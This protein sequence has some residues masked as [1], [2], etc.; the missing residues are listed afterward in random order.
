LQVLI[1]LCVPYSRIYLSFLAEELRVKVEE[2]VVL[3]ADLILDGALNAKID[4]INGVLISESTN[5]ATRCAAI[6][7]C[8][9][10]LSSL[11][12]SIVDS[13]STFTPKGE[14]AV[15]GKLSDF[16]FRIGNWIAR[17]KLSNLKAAFSVIQEMASSSAAS[18]SS[19]VNPTRI[20]AAERRKQIFTSHFPSDYFCSDK[21]NFLFVAF[22]NI[23]DSIVHVFLGQLPDD[24]L[25][26]TTP[27][28]V[29]VQRQQQQSVVPVYITDPNLVTQQSLLQA[30]QAF[31]SFVPPNTRGRLSITVVSAKLVKNYGLVRMD[32]YCCV[33]VGNAVFET[34]KDTNGGKTPKW[35]RIINSYLPFGVESFYLQIFD[36]KAF[37]ADECIAWAHIILP[38]G[39][40]CGEIIDDWY[41]LSGQQGEGKEGVINLITSFT[42]V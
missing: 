21:F 32:P 6:A 27:S 16:F 1:G 18:N 9:K 7:K 19:S 41:Q 23:N 14:W 12:L 29:S 4:E 40:F 22:Y 26:I 37:T 13:N 3:L 35:N 17:S 31:Y 24:F 11:H 8:A 28:P 34:P 30:Q 33:R 20:S 38:N 2:V 36:E 39:I 42:P 15:P 10:Q 25:R 5:K